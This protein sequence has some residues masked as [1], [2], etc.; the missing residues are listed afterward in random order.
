MT[1]W[2]VSANNIRL[3]GT[4]SGCQCRAFSMA[5]VA[6]LA[7]AASTV[8]DES[9]DRPGDDVNMPRCRQCRWCRWWAGLHRA[10]PQ[11]RLVEVAVDLD[12]GALQG[13][14]PPADLKDFLSAST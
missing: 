4:A 8:I 14:A 12:V 5:I 6:A 7:L 2:S 9:L 3:T 11:E 10:R 1:C 13:E